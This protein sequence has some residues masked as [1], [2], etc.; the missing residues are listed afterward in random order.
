L[1]FRIDNNHHHSSI[2][3]MIGVLLKY[4]SLFSF[5]ATLVS[6]RRLGTDYSHQEPTLDTLRNHR[7]LI[8]PLFGRPIDDSYIIV[9]KNKL[10]DDAP[11]YRVRN[12]L[13]NS[14]A[15]L[16]YEYNMDTVKGFAVHGLV[17]RIL[18]FI[19]SDDDVDYVEQDQ[20][21]VGDSSTSSFVA[22]SQSQPVN[23]A[24]DR[25]DQASLPL[26]NQYSYTLTGTY[27]LRGQNC[28]F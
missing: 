24:L 27:I 20:V 18:A 8:A 23:W 2:T 26:D 13:R 5:A 3:V 28:S 10:D 12:I 7:K 17:A 4:V 11:F 19:L 22:Q 14:G 1:L 15:M 6:A 16:T 9:L 21:V 25:I